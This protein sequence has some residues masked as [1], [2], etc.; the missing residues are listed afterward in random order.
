MHESKEVCPP[1][2]FQPEEVRVGCT[3]DCKTCEKPGRSVARQDARDTW[4]EESVL[5]K[6][7]DVQGQVMRLQSS[8]EELEGL[9]Q[10]MWPRSGRAPSQKVTHVTAGRNECTGSKADA[11]ITACAS[12]PEPLPPLQGSAIADGAV[13]ELHAPADRLQPNVRPERANRHIHFG[14]EEDVQRFGS[15]SPSPGSST[16]AGILSLS[17]SLSL[18]LFLSLH[19]PPP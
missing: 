10:G 13:V 12:S 17:L 6:E 5:Q 4:M 9:L 16:S 1:L 15:N 19:S 3:N 2:E 11:D 8:L 14:I 18:S 7:R